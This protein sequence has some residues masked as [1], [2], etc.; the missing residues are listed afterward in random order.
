MQKTKLL[1][2]EY[3]FILFSELNSSC[4]TIKA[5]RQSMEITEAAIRRFAKQGIN[6]STILTIAK[7][8]AVSAK[9]IYNYFGTFDELVV[10]SLKYVRLLYQN[11]VVE[12]L[13]KNIESGSPPELL[14][15]Y[16][17]ACFEWPTVYKDHSSFW[18]SFLHECTKNKTFKELNTKMVQVGRERIESII[19]VKINKEENLTVLAEILHQLLTSYLLSMSTES[20]FDRKKAKELILRCTHQLL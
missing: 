8:S 1:N 17:D 13:N 11:F 7:D 19:R 10:H 2:F 4:K 18:I 5:K 9:T 16:L 3:R 20:S 14:E 12:E 15:I 6:K